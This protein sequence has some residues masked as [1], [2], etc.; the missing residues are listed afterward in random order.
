MNSYK[1]LKEYENNLE[2]LEDILGNESTTDVELKHLGE[3]LFFE[4]FAAVFQLI[5]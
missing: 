2:L 1:I 3:N 4:R 5:K